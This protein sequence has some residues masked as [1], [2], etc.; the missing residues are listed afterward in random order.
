MNNYTWNCIQSH[1]QE[2]KRLLG[3][4]YEQLFDL[5]EYL[6]LLEKQEN[7]DKEN[8]KIRLNQAGGGRDEKL[9]KE[10]QKKHGSRKEKNSYF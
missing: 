4:S 10:E 9:S 6:K 7:E 8:K 5:I 1:P 2:T 3:I